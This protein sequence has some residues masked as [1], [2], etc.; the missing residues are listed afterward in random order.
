VTDLLIAYVLW[1]P[2]DGTRLGRGIFA[3]TTNIRTQL[4][5]QN[6][7]LVGFGFTFDPVS[8]VERLLFLRH[9]PHNLI[10]KT[11]CFLADGRVLNCLANKKLERHRVP[12][13]LERPAVCC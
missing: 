5:F 10:I 3:F 2:C 8:Q 4:A 9:L 13:M 1:E 11:G 7:A 6:I 12:R